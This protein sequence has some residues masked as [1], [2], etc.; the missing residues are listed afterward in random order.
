M[1]VPVGFEG[2]TEVYHAPKGMEAECSDLPVFADDSCVISCWRLDPAELAE[3]AVT[4]VVWLRVEGT[5]ITPMAVSGEAM[6]IVTMSDGS[7][8]PSVAEPIIPLAPR[9]VMP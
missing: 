2:A 8:R 6:V 4:G 5:R 7:K 9:K 3:I 1:A